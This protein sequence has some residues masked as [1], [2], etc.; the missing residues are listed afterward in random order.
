MI[1]CFLLFGF[2]NKIK[3]M[4]KASLPIKTKIAAWL[5]I[6]VGGLLEIAF[7]IGWIKDITQGIWYGAGL[8]FL[9]LPIFFLLPGIFIILRNKSA[10]WF[11]T[12]LLLAILIFGITIGW[13]FI[14]GP[15]ISGSSDLT[16]HLEILI[17][18]VFPLTALIL[19][20]LD[21]KN[22]WKIAS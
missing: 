20:L 5:L 11:S 4:E 16:F 18:I 1:K 7:L 3:L 12:I 17:L 15:V 6:L 8:P 10:W 21:R 9:L 19:L 2:W 14:L 13:Q 22:F